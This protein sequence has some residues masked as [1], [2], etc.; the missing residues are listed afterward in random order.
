MTDWTAKDL[1]VI[2]AADKL[3]IALVRP[4]GSLRPYA[5]IWVVRV[6]DEWYV[7]SYRGPLA[8]GFVTY[9]NA[10]TAPSVP[11]ASNATSRLIIC[12]CAKAGP[13]LVT[14]ARATI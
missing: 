12:R 9:A 14:G 4:D 13:A 10:I 7:R 1:D 8:A 6:S 11:E 5:T 3:S 2:G